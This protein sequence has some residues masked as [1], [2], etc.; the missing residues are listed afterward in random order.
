MLYR[1]HH[2][3]RFK[4]AHQKEIPAHYDQDAPGAFFLSLTKCRSLF[5]QILFSD[6]WEAFTHSSLTILAAWS[7]D[8]RVAEQPPLF[9]D[10]PPHGLF[11][12]VAD[13]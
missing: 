12:K 4:V 1:H 2:K 7:L 13:A 6:L 9:C 5:S 3:S 8:K 11:L 10:R